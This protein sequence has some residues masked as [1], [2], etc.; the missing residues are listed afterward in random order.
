MTMGD[1]APAIPALATNHRVVSPPG[2]TERYLLRAVLLQ[3][4]PGRPDS[5]A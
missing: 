3:P 1:Q 5:P 4:A 2:A